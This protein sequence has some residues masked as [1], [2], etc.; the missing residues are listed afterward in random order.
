MSLIDGDVDVNGDM[1][2]DTDVVVSDDAAVAV[3]VAATAS[4]DGVSIDGDGDDV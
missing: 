1:N 3:V 4:N 2:G